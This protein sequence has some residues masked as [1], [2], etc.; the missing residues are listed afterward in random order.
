MISGLGLCGSSKEA[1]LSGYGRAVGFLG[2]N[3]LTQE[4]S[5]K[6]N[7]KFGADKYTGTYT[8]SYDGY[9]GTEYLFGGTHI[10]RKYGET[11]ALKADVKAIDGNAKVF[12]ISGDKNP[13]ILAQNNEEFDGVLNAGSGSFYIGVNC[14]NFSGVVA[15]VSE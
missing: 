2:D 14:D 15:I 7:R 13:K 11:V 5:L 4:F 8:A 9:S 12:L 1:L 3:V 6:G 10:E